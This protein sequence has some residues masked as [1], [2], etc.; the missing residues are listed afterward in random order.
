MRKIHIPE[1]TEMIESSKKLKNYT[2]Y[3][4]K[5]KDYLN[6]VYIIYRNK[7]HDNN[8]SKDMRR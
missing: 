3:F 5:L 8:F 1:I 4:L 7:L 6:E 2:L